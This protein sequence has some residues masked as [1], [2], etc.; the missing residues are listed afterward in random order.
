MS[1]GFA[2]AASLLDDALDD[3]WDEDQ[4]EARDLERA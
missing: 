3:S 2:L 4:I 1:L